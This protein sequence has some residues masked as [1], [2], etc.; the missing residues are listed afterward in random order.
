MRFVHI[1]LLHFEDALQERMRALIWFLM[2][3]VN[4]LLLIISW[5]GALGK[6]GMMNGWTRTDINTYYL[7]LIVTSSILISHVE[8]KIGTMDIREG[9]LVRYL[10]RPFSYFWLCFFEEI[11]Y[12]LLQGIFA[13]IGFI[14]LTSLIPITHI[15]PVTIWTLLILIGA[16]LLSFLMQASVAL[17]AFW[18]VEVG[19]IFDTLEVVRLV[20]GGTILPII[21][22]PNW[23]INIAYLSPFAYT[24]YFP[25]T[26]IQ[27]KLSSET[28]LWVLCMQ[29]IWIILFIC[30]YKILWFFGLKKFSGVGQ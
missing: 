20:L 2:S 13:V 25:I 30:L 4:P 17:I 27:G 5:N 22:L 23:I 26:S 6:S 29:G 1:L 11:P 10:T 28:Q 24:A 3:L 14:I 18:I 19:G 21:L 15:P 8:D 9:G 16:L 12:R 7:L